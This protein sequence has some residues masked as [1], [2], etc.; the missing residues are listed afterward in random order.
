MNKYQKFGIAL[1]IVGLSFLAVAS[2][3][4]ATLVLSPSAKTVNVG[5][6]F[7]AQVLLDTQGQ[8]VDG[9][10]VH[11]LN[12]NPYNLKMVQIQ[13][14][15]LMANT[16]ANSADTT[17]GKILFSQI[18]NPGSTYTGN[19]VLATV[20]FK[21][22]VA[23][24]TNVTFDFTLGGTTNSNVASQGNNILTSV[25]N[26]AFT[27][28]NAGGS[29]AGVGSPVPV[30]N[31]GGSTGGNGGNSGGNGGYS[32][33]SNPTS[34]SLAQL[35]ALLAQLKAQLK[36][37]VLQAIARGIKLPPGLA[38]SLGIYPSTGVTAGFTRN[39]VVGMSG[40]DV[41]S[42]QKFLNSHG[43]VI[44]ASGPGS[45]GYEVSVFGLKTKAA[46]IKYQASVGLP[47]TG[48]FGALTRAK[49]SA[50]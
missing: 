46:L 21:A 49:V 47:A 2:A 8:A 18:T 33:G 29:N 34:M 30:G 31:P 45:P 42:L 3:G 14:G 43:F 20:T 37:L 10:D 32:G 41:I 28:N 25:V 48:Y 4:A 40:A 23:G 50:Q 19:G 12:Y 16:V 15:T 39:L 9:V 7:T 35:L 38:E 36:A 22:L 17:N 11:A 27:I 24:T 1:G 13:P 5:D 26:G 6:T 44:A